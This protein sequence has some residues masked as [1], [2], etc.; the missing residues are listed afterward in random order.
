MQDDTSKRLRLPRKM[1]TIPWQCDSHKIRRTTR[2][3]SKALRLPRN[4]R[5]LRLKYWACHENWN[6]SSENVVKNSPAIKK[7]FSTRYEICLNVTK[8]HACCAKRSNATFE[9]S[10]NGPFCRISYRH[11]IQGLRE[12]LRT[13]RQRR[14]KI[15]S[16]PRPPEW[17]GNLATHSGENVFF[18]TR[19]LPVV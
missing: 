12:R 6:L 19:R 7:R 18:Y 17:N 14:A 11:G 2:L 1:T 10:K 3:E 5:R 9:A 16:A 8:C 13:V 4:W 15:P